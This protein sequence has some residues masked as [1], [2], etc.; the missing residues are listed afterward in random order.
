MATNPHTHTDLV[1]APLGNDLVLTEERVGRPFATRSCGAPS[2]AE[3]AG[4]RRW[5]VAPPPSV[6]HVVTH[7]DGD[8]GS[9]HAAHDGEG[10][11][12]RR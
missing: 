4:R 11:V 10:D 6:G 5:P 1:Q 3:H 9:A 12:V 7:S 8:A 2:I